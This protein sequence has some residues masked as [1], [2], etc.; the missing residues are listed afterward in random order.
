MRCMSTPPADRDSVQYKSRFVWLVVQGIRLSF[1]ISS[2]RKAA[3][4][5][6]LLIGTFLALMGS[7]AHGQSLCLS[8]LLWSDQLP[9]VSAASATRPVTCPGGKHTTAHAECC[10]LFPIV[11]DLQNNFFENICGEE[12][13]ESLR[14]TFHDAIG[15]SPA[16]TRQ[17]KFGGGGADGS[18]IVFDEIETKFHANNG[19]DDIVGV[20]KDIR[21]PSHD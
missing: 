9:T 7:A 8:P 2:P 19:I 12:V 14:L 5:T 18:V 16:L 20:D 10:A 3:M 21:S 11:E 4:T 17:G 6:K 15:F 1:D 13:H